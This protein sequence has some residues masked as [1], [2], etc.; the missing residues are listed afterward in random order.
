MGK[1][2]EA[3]S[4]E[5]SL[6]GLL[7]YRQSIHS[8]NKIPKTRHNI[9]VIN[10]IITTI[11][12]STRGVGTFSGFRS[13]P[14]GDSGVVFGVCDTVGGFV[15]GLSVDVEIIEKSAVC[16]QDPGFSETPCKVI[17]SHSHFSFTDKSGQKSGVCWIR[18]NH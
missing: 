10:M 11:L 6:G 4:L 14:N 9:T 5:A 15:I 2:D 13:G 1:S 7:W 16:L 18:N 3:V 12:F 17:S 8:E